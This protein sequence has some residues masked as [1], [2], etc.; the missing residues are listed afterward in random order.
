MGRKC[1][2]FHRLLMEGRRLR[3]IRNCQNVISQ[4]CIELHAF[5]KDGKTSLQLYPELRMAAH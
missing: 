4:Y 5:L 1:G 3:S 2:S